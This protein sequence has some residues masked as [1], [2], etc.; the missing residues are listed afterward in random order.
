MDLA[1]LPH[2]D[3]D[4]REAETARRQLRFG[5]GDRGV[6]VVRIPDDP[7]A[8]QPGKDLAQHLQALA[9]ELGGELRHPRDVAAG[10]VQAR[11][12]PLADRV[13]AVGH[14][15]GNDLRGV[16]CRHDRLGA[17]SDDDVDL[18]LDELG[19]HGR[20]L[21]AG[22]REAIEDF[23]VPAR[24]VAARGEAV[25]QRLH[26]RRAHRGR[27]GGEEPDPIGPGRRRR[28]GGQE[29]KADQKRAPVHAG[30]AGGLPVTLRPRLAR[31]KPG[32]RQ[33][34]Q[35]SRR[36]SSGLGCGR[37]SFPGA[38]PRSPRRAGAR[39]SEARRRS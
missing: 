5:E 12:E 15:D 1:R 2:L 4:R 7:D 33:A 18:A 31:S 8:R 16:A 10:P 32:V 36:R 13:A 30:S 29:G 28:W 34:G 25:P 35:G 21:F 38:R 19:S 3:R 22:P 6:R 24:L 17:C 39:S 11:R 9:D 23:E 26:Q 37:C 27:R 14:D 20:Q